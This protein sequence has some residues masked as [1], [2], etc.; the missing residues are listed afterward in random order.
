MDVV[1]D[2]CDEHKVGVLEVIM[3]PIYVKDLCETVCREDGW[4]QWMCVRVCVCV[5]VYVCVCLCV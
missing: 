2:G 3:N 1:S 4:L 5:C